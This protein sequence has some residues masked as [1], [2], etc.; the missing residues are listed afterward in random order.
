[1]HKVQ[2]LKMKIDMKAEKTVKITGAAPE[3]SMT[4]DVDNDLWYEFNAEYMKL[5][6]MEYYAMYKIPEIAGFRKHLSEVRHTDEWE[7]IQDHMEGITHGEQHQV[8]VK[9]QAKLLIEALKTIHMT[10]KDA[11]WVDPHYSPVMFDVWHM[12]YL[13]FVAVGKGDI[14]PMLDFLIDGKYDEEFV[15]KVDPKFGAPEKN[16]Y[17]F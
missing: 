4:V 14:D 8:V 15:K 7:G 1:M 6:E 2:A 9:H 16:L 12:V 10:D 3:R 13:Y 5:R 11:K 17:L